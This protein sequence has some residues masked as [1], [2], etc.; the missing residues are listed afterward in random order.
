MNDDKATMR[1]R[2]RWLLVALG[3]KPET[4]DTLIMFSIVAVGHLCEVNFA[5]STTRRCYWYMLRIA[6]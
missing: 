1:I 4:G 6:G 3:A 2:D 5:C